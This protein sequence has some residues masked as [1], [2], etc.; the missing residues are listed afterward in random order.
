MEGVTVFGHPPECRVVFG[1]VSGKEST[2][3][4][5]MFSCK[6]HTENALPDGIYVLKRPYSSYAST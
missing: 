2:Q 5:E 6:Q 3:N 1:R 4:V